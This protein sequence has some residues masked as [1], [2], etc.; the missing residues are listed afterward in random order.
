VYAVNSVHHVPSRELQARLLDEVVRVLRP[1]GSFALCE[2]NTENPLF[3]L[4]MG[5]VFPLLRRIDDGTELWMR[6][7]SLPAVSGAAWST[8]VSYQ[9]FLPD[10]L[11]RRLVD[12]L[13]PV[14]RRLEASRLRRW[15]AHF[16]AYLVK[17]PATDPAAS[18]TSTSRAVASG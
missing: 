14:E 13:D 12:V 3:R 10:F 9:T 18:T 6:P 8:D 16:Q 5:Y 4:Y 7:S 1:G 15:S 17:D 2:I 11:P